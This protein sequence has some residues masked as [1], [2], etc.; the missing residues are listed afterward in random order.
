MGEAVGDISTTVVPVT[1]T[2]ASPLL[3]FNSMK[4]FPLVMDSSNS[5]FTMSVV[6]PSDT[7][8]VYTN[9]RSASSLRVELLLLSVT[10]TV[11]SVTDRMEGPTVV[12]MLNSTA[13]AKSLVEV[14][15]SDTPARICVR[16][17]SNAVRY[18]VT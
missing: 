17:N 12:M 6:I 15:D 1:L 11:T 3:S 8:I 18:G 13:E 7:V 5:I 14:S 9:I 2:M 4:Y 10:D 16:T